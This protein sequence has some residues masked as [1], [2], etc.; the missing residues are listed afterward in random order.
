MPQKIQQVFGEVI[1]RRREAAGVSQE[2]LGHSS[3]LSRN[4]IGMLERGER[5]PTILVLHKLAVAL[6]A[7]MSLLVQELERGLTAPA[8]A[9]NR[10]GTAGG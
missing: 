8:R 7:S 6:G 3:G 1:R 9:R 4:Y 2:D 10:R 5:V